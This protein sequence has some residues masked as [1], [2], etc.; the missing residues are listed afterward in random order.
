[1]LLITGLFSYL[2]VQ[3][4]YWEI[5]GG[6]AL[7]L[8][9]LVILILSSIGQFTGYNKGNR[10]SLFVHI[11]FLLIEPIWLLARLYKKIKVPI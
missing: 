1:M 4:E 3:L 5:A 8:V 2:I 11:K 10:P 6:P 7:W 9:C